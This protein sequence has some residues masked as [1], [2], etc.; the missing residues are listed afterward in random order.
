ML[1]P[2]DAFAKASSYIAKAPGESKALNL[3]SGSTSPATNTG[4]ASLVRTIV[5]LAIVI[6]VIWGIA[7]LL[8]QV[9]SGREGKAAGLGLTSMATLPLGS[10]RSL[11][12]VR[13]GS[14]YV[15]VGVA[16]H[17][18][19]PVHRYT[20][21]QAREAGL[22]SVG[23]ANPMLADETAAQPSGIPGQGPD[24]ALDRLRRWTVRA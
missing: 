7:W 15:L 16:E 20:E 8:R 10:G 12:L 14:D 17:G 2:G 5:G 13:A 19:V 22:L 18:V 3:S 9:K 6:A 24:T 11:Q 1:A 21:Q 23:T 4:G